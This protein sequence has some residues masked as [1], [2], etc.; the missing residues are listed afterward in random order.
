MHGFS[1]THILGPTTYMAWTLCIC[2]C[3][4]IFRY[5]IYTFYTYSKTDMGILGGQGW[6]G[7]KDREGQD[8]D[9][10]EEGQWW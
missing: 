2:V 9:R 6:E 7:W 4:Y 1:L 10:I 8:R 5:N 3:F